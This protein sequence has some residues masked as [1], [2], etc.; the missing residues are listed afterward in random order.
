M[1]THA[2]LSAA[3]KPKTP[4]HAPP[5]LS[6]ILRCTG[7][8]P[9]LRVGAVDDPAEAEADRI[10]DQV[11][12]IREPKAGDVVHR[13]C[14]ACEDEDNLHRKEASAASRQGGALSPAAESLVRNLGPGIPLPASERAFFEPRFG[15]DLSGV[16]IHTDSIASK[17][18]DALNAHAF[19]VGHN[20]VF[21]N[22]QFAPKMEQSRQILAHELAHVCQCSNSLPSNSDGLIRRLT[23]GELE[24][25]LWSYVPD[26]AKPFV[27]PIAR[28]AKHKIEIVIPPNTE[29]PK[30]IE[31]TVVQPT[32]HAADSVVKNVSVAA[33]DIEKAK[34]KLSNLGD[35]A[36]NKIKQAARGQIERK[37]GRTKGVFLEATSLFDTIAWA[38][39]EAHR[40]LE[41]ATSDN[42]SA[43]TVLSIADY[44][45][46]YSGSMM[47]AKKLGLVDAE[48]GAP[49]VSSAF[50]NFVDTNVEKGLT[51]LLGPSTEEN[52]LMFTEYELGELEGAI[53]TQVALSFVGAEE[54]QLVLKGIG[55]LG[56]V[57]GL[58]DAIDANKGSW[59]KD[60]Q[61]WSGI[62]NIVLSVLSLKAGSK[63]GGKIVAI[64]LASGGVLNAVPAIW[65]LYN[66][67]KATEGKPDREKI[68]KRD[69]G[70]V[71]KI[72][73]QVV[74][75][76]IKHDSAKKTSAE[77][78]SIAPTIDQAPSLTN[79]EPASPHPDSAL[80]KTTQEE[81]NRT[82]TPAVD[83]EKPGA[84]Q[85]I[86]DLDHAPL[87]DEAKVKAQEAGTGEH[88]VKVTQDGI[89]VCS[90][91]PCP[92]LHL[93]Y[94]A[95][96]KKN[97]LLQ[98]DVLELDALR[99]SDPVAA[100][101]KAKIVQ[102]LLENARKNE[103]KID[104]EFDSF[105]NLTKE[106]EDMPNLKSLGPK[107]SNQSSSQLTSG[108]LLPDLI[109]HEQRR[110][111]F[112]QLKAQ[113]STLKSR[114]GKTPDG[115]EVNPS[116]GLQS[117]HI[118]PQSV[119]FNDPRYN[120]QKMITRL[121][122]TGRGHKHT[123]FDQHWQAQFREIRERTGRNWTTV[124][125][126]TK[127]VSKAARESGAF[128]AGE[129]ESMVQLLHEDMKVQ[130]GLLD[131]DV[132]RMPGA[133]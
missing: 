113:D 33:P 101:K 133:N 74:I 31:Q 73:S 41:K 2:Q 75:D 116:P 14:A 49:A 11:M 81:A 114:P 69:M 93:E 132:L 78:P 59:Y 105:M 129:A 106:A 72:L 58:V 88:E 118:T 6:A 38:N 50:G 108:A 22:C 40:I 110:D 91:K 99:K 13:K 95:E 16:R 76:I 68:I 43:K 86:E 80:G 107:S 128:T 24:R 4:L 3:P 115:V 39:F 12:R 100:A 121:L 65:Q 64:V 77:K 7:I 36:K 70:N 79:H 45:T 44:I 87:V 25:K 30:E 109:H 125:E 42:A 46:G 66:D 104:A 55:A 21:G 32:L 111:A 126:V 48:T 124:E 17:T 63:A 90:P 37:I 28:E 127:V 130:M 122:P 112:Q 131:T 103:A 85:K 62:L 20:I 19:A 56:A 89:Y 92:V 123:L 98:Q 96:L 29:I 18:A 1:H 52:S 120:P 97:K 51:S 34:R 94:A 5:N 27:E 26:A 119:F 15:R 23:F 84:K 83:V 67:W 82:K 35:Y 47:A 60:P 9:K 102:G 117:A 61:M 71:I 8:H 57:K 54:V 10:A 53:G